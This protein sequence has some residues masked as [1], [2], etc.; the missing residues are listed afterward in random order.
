MDVSSI[1]DGFHC[2]CISCGES[3]KQDRGVLNI[4]IEIPEGFLC[5]KCWKKRIDT[6][7]ASDISV[8]KQHESSIISCCFCILCGKTPPDPEVKI[9]VET[10]RGCLCE[11]CLKR[12]VIEGIE[13]EIKNMTE[14]E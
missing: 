2:N 12:I 10:Q 9:W 4:W 13:R 7:N 1:K 3:P 5:E 11:M 6:I 14:G 8:K